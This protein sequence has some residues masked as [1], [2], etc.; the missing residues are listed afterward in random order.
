[1]QTVH[2]R[3]LRLRMLV[4]L[5]V[6]SWICFSNA[7]LYSGFHLKPSWFSLSFR[8]G[9]SKQ[10][11]GEAVFL[12]GERGP[13][14]EQVSKVP[15]HPGLV[16]SLVDVVIGADDVELAAA[17]ALEGIVN[18]LVGQPRRSRLVGLRRRS[19]APRCQLGVRVSRDD[20][21]R[22]KLR[23]FVEELVCEG[24]FPGTRQLSREALSKRVEFAGLYLR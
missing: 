16:Q 8:T 20:Q 10:S 2:V 11:A 1:M 17:D 23:G 5:P 19:G 24:C 9:Q 6:R 22:R 14:L 13:V 7:S 18:D 12:P 15:L 3:Y 21:V 4:Y